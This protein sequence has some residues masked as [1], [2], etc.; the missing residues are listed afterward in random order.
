M[1]CSSDSVGHLNL[2]GPDRMLL[3]GNLT[4]VEIQQLDLT[5]EQLVV[6]AV[7]GV[8]SGWEVGNSLI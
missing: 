5:A 1:L 3:G 2:K 7:G 6:H 4:S 8:L